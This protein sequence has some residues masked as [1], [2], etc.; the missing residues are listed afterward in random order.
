MGGLCDTLVFNLSW[1][2]G[3]TYPMSTA[4]PRI[5]EVML[6]IV[7]IIVVISLIEDFAYTISFSPQNHVKKSVSK[8]LYYKLKK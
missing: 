5:T 8:S 7:K 1:H 2:V 6:V 3:S 4:L